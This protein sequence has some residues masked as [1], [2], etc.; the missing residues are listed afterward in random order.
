MLDFL[1]FW[2]KEKEPVNTNTSAYESALHNVA[3]EKR[4]R[5]SR[6]E[7]RTRY[8]LLRWL[9][10]MDFAGSTT[11][12]GPIHL[13]T[14]YGLTRL[15]YSFVVFLMAIMFMVHS[16]HLAQQYL[17]YPILTAIKYDNVDFH[18]PDITICPNSPFTDV[19]LYKNNET[20]EEVKNIYGMAKELWWRSPDIL[21]MSPNAR[22]KRSMTRQFYEKSKTIGKKVFDHV[23]FCEVRS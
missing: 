12:H 21:N 20:A 7:A 14:T 19:Q 23:I 15:Y 13:S 9:V 8:R 16:G 17:G 2:R 3:T 11:L 1:K 22:I 4:F 6:N 5:G 10:W 18:Y